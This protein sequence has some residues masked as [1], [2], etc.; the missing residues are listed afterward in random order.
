[1]DTERLVEEINLVY[2]TDL[3]GNPFDEANSNPLAGHPISHRLDTTVSMNTIQ[4][5]M[6]V[7]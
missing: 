5:Y 7:Q 1:M 3:I 2:D 4:R 6:N